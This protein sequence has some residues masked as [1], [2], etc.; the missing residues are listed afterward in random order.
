M[1]RSVRKGLNEV[2]VAVAAAA[3]E[4]EELGLVLVEVPMEDS[5]AKVVIVAVLDIT[6]TTIKNLITKDKIRLKCSG[7]LLLLLLNFFIF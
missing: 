7:E 4:E 6:G 1:T 2:V 3:A 5:G